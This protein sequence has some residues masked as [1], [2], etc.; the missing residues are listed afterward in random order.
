MQPAAPCSKLYSMFKAGDSS[1]CISL[2]Q[3]ESAGRVVGIGVLW[4]YLDRRRQLLC[5]ALST[6]LQRKRPRRDAHATSAANF[7]SGFR[8]PI[9]RHHKY[10]GSPS[11]RV[12]AAHR[13]GR[14]SGRMLDFI[15]GTKKLVLS[16]L[17][18]RIFSTHHNP[19]SDSS[20]PG[21]SCIS[22]SIAARRGQKPYW[23]IGRAIRL[24]AV[25][26]NTR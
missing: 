11:I 23:W 26:R 18:C 9:M 10:V 13:I 19:A 2:G 8:P 20:L 24:D 6:I 1:R 12:G 21:K 15:S 4:I 7:A 25:T 5:C 17:A 14:R 22:A 16:S 3:L